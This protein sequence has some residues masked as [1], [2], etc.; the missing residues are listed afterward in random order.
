MSNELTLNATWG[1]DPLPA[2]GDGQ[3]AYLL[4]DLTA[5]PQAEVTTTTTPLNLALVL[6]HSGSMSG[7][8][9]QHMKEAV[10]RLIDQLGPQD[11]LSMDVRPGGAFRAVMHLPDGN[12]IDWAGTYIEVDPPAHLAMTLTDQPGDD[13]GLPV[14]FDLEPVDGGT[15]LTVRQ[16]RS[17]FSDEQVA[18]TIAG[19]H[20]FLDDLA[21]VVASMS[22]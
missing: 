2:G 15:Q 4:L 6:D 9:L 21:R 11:T 13:P 20:A 16:D 3:L 17:D 1:R 12:R 8:K 10:Q 22:R 5:N 18:A 14:I 19:Y 7:P